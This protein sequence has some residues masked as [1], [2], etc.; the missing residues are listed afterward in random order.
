MQRD[1]EVTE[2]LQKRE[3][4]VLRFWDNEIKKNVSGSADVIEKTVRGE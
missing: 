3:W 1:I 4:K 2:E